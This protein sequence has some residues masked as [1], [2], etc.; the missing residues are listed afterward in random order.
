MDL[1]F[2]VLTG[3]KIAGKDPELAAR[4]RE[5][6]DQIEA[7]ADELDDRYESPFPVPTYDDL[8]DT[9]TWGNKYIDEDA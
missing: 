6:A 5:M 7:L 1:R 8:P 2:P 9:V 4:L 3:K